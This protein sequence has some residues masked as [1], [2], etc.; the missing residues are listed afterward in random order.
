MWHVV[1]SLGDCYVLSKFNTVVLL[2]R[3]GVFL[4]GFKPDL[5]D[6]LISFSALTLL[7]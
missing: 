6:Q 2:Y 4:V 7:I 5:D 3:G 1:P